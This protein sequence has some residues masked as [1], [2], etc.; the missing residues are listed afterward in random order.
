MTLQG[1]LSD[2]LYSD[3]SQKQDDAKWKQ[4]KERK[5]DDVENEDGNGN[6]CEDIARTLL[7]FRD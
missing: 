5:A 1:F 3:Y 6:K 4:D 2:W 7:E